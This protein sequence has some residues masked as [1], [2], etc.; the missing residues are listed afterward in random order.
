MESFIIGWEE[1][2]AW[3]H[4]SNDPARH[5]WFSDDVESLYKYMFSNIQYSRRSRLSADEI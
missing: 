4:W 1:P 3:V 5:V 2:K